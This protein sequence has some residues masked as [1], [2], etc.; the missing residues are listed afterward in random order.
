MGLERA[1][2][3]EQRTD[4]TPLYST[5]VLLYFTYVVS[6]FCRWRCSM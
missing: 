2:N 4:H 6:R 1:A 5:F 3:L